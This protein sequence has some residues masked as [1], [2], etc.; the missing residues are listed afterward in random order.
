MQTRIAKLIFLL[1]LISFS[2]GCATFKQFTGPNGETL[3]SIDCSG[4]YSNVGTCLK[5]AG[6]ICGSAGY[7]IIMGDATNH[8]AMATGSPYGFYSGTIIS[9]E[10]I[11]RCKQT[12]Q[13]GADI[14]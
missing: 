8:G 4:Y 2:A 11:I 14:G 1:C 12:T 13:S 9:R 6:E 7:D 5:K 3:Y 10:V